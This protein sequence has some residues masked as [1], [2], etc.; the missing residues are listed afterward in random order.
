MLGAMCGQRC[1]VSWVGWRP[2]CM[3]RGYRR[4]GRLYATAVC[5]CVCACNLSV[6]CAR[7]I[8]SRSWVDRQWIVAIRRFCADASW[9]GASVKPLT[10]SRSSVFVVVVRRYCADASRRG[11][12]VKPLTV[13]RSSVFVVV[14][15]YSSFLCQRLSAWRIGKT[16]DR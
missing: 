11:A 3:Y 16:V 1:A 4:C 12:S 5:R 14:R 2:G 7:V 9:R 15:R 10:V 6:A 8:V 13:S